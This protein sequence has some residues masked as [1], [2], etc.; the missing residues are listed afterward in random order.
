VKILCGGAGYSFFLGG[1]EKIYSSKKN[2]QILFQISFHTY[3]KMAVAEFGNFFTKNSGFFFWPPTTS[4]QTPW[5]IGHFQ[6][7]DLKKIDLRKWPPT[8]WPRKV[9]NR[10]KP[11]GSWVTDLGHCW[12]SPT[13]EKLF[14]YF[15]E[16]FEKSCCKGFTV[17]IFS[18]LTLQ[19]RPCLPVY[20][21]V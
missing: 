3:R 7:G 1:G 17:K 6:K 2:C 21:A 13:P 15:F 14:F 16:I 12:G 20:F 19:N 10:P 8:K 18:K 11:L 5:V 9:T 4:P